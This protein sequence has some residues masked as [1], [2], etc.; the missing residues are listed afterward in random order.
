MAQL[1]GWFKQFLDSAW[2]VGVISFGG[3]LASAAVVYFSADP[4]ARTIGISLIASLVTV[5]VV[6][7]IHTVREDLRREMKLRAAAIEST[8]VAVDLARSVGEI[9]KA[10]LR[11]VGARMMNRVEVGV[12]QLAGY[13]NNTFANQGD[14]MLWATPRIEFL[15]PTGAVLAVCGDKDW[16]D[17]AVRAFN[18]TNCEVAARGCRVERIFLQ[19]DAAGFSRGE[20][21]VLNEHLAAEKR[22]ANIVP[23]V[24]PPRDATRLVDD[25]LLPPGF[26]FTLI[27]GGIEPVVLVH[28]GLADDRR[29]GLYITAP[30]VVR[31]F[32]RIYGEFRQ[33]AHVYTGE[34]VATPSVAT[35]PVRQTNV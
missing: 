28:W 23:Y 25:Y 5:N 7:H 8:V 24:V 32:E 17:D 12:A 3:G 4:A 9:R 33:R 22:G 21:E 16:E 19:Y 10:F 34:A 6:K 2:S 35:V 26:G 30:E 13:A 27:H 15:P 29:G 11:Q 20:Q 31:E 18:R 1:K 14:Y